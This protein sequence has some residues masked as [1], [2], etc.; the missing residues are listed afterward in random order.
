M[1]SELKYCGSCILAAFGLLISACK[2]LSFEGGFSK[3][4]SGASRTE[5]N[6]IL[7]APDERREM[8]LPEGSFWGPQEDLSTVLKPGTPF[9]EWVYHRDGYDYYV[10]FASPT[11]EPR[12]DWKVVQK[13]SCPEDAVF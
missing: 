7:G 5:V 6:S 12:E 4:E 2:S 1:M 9:E 13:A 10:W 8:R 11:G 3:V